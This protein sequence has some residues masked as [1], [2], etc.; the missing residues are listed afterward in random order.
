VF[1]SDFY[2]ELDPYL[3]GMYQHMKKEIF[4]IWKYCY[5]FEDV[6]QSEENGGGEAAFV[7]FIKKCQVETTYYFDGSTDE[8]LDEQLKS[9]YL[10]QEFS[11]FVFD[12]QGVDGDQL[13]SDFKSFVKDKQPGELIS[14][15]WKAGLSEQ[16]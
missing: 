2:G 4:A 8:S 3:K 13:L 6:M 9:L 5:G 16:N 1:V 14:P 7:R 15:T 10:K 11:K 12:H